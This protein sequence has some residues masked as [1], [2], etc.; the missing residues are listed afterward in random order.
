MSGIDGT[1]RNNKRLNLVAETF[2]RKAQMLECHLL[3]KS[4]EA[5]H[6]F[7]EH[8]CWISGVYDCKSLRPKPAGVVCPSLVSSNACWLTGDA[9]GKD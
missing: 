7:K 9:S 4:K 3:L 2:Q 1:S 8:P 5:R 6:I